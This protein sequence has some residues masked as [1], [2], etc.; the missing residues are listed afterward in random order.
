[1][2]KYKDSD[3]VTMMSLAEQADDVAKS[4]ARIEYQ[5]FIAE[6]KY[7][8]TVRELEKRQSELEKERDQLA[9]Q[10]AEQIKRGGSHAET[11]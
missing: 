8:E 4:L 6:D 5:K 9:R 1:M 11:R 2:R 10:I 3:L 7:R